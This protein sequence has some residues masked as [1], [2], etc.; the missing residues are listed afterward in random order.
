M[1]SLTSMC[2]YSNKRIIFVSIIYF[3][4]INEHISS[5]TIRIV[6]ICRHE[7]VIGQDLTHD[8]IVHE[9]IW[10]RAKFDPLPLLNPQP[11]VTK[12]CAGNYV[13]MSNMHPAKFC[14][15]R[16]RGFACALPPMRD[17]AH[18][19]L[20]CYFWPTRSCKMVLP[21]L[22]DRCPVLSCPVCDVGVLWPNGWMY[23][24]EPWQAGRPRLRPYCV[25]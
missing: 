21:R 9:L 5:W 15:D 13:G 18:H 7:F 11:I 12:I 3:T 25:S 17:F 2:M 23:Q 14:P 20:L 16:I 22:S 24:D 1:N 10:G 19:C 4:F 6:I 8:G